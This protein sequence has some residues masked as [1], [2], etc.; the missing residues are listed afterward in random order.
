MRVKCIC[1]ECIEDGFKG[2]VMKIYYVANTGRTIV[3]T[4]WDDGSESAMYPDELEVIHV[5]GL[6]PI[7][8]VHELQKASKIRGG[9]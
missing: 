2:E 7:E 5:T 8:W 1:K 6:E 4:K 9:K 3:D